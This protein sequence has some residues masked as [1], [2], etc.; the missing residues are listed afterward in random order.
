MTRY[1]IYTALIGVASV[2]FALAIYFGDFDSNVRII[3]MAVGAVIF[4]HSA[5][6]L[7]R[8]AQGKITM[9]GEYV[10]EEISQIALLNTADEIVSTWEL[11]GRTS[12]VI[13]KDF[14]E[15]QVDVDLS[16]TPY[17]AMID[18]EHAVLNYVGGAWYVED[19]G[20]QNGIS[21]KKSGQKETYKLSS[22]QPCKLDLGDIIFVGMCRLKFN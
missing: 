6:T 15:N 21:I 7:Y 8:S 2:L 17:S 18:V 9:P 19:L 11:Y 3:F 14:G 22:L 20:S 5:F 10:P 13:G 12:A 16:A 1:D 4:L